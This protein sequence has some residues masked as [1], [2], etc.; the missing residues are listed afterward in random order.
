MSTY[1]AIGGVSESLKRLLE[2]TI[3]LP[4]SMPAV[5]PPFPVW[6]GIPPKDDE[7]D[8]DPLLNLFLYRITES[9]FLK[10]QEI[11]KP[12]P[13]SSYGH[14]PLSLDLHY[15][16]TP[17]GRLGNGGAGTSPDEVP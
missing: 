2:N 16:V 11:P 13:Q 5:P 8:G 12:S 15:L 1:E 7:L 14:S 10:N 6:I 4:S 9:P 17:Y 3:E